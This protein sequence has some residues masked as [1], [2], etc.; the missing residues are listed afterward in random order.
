MA[1][2]DKAADD[3]ATNDTG[4]G[5]SKTNDLSRGLGDQVSASTQTR[6]D[7]PGFLAKPVADKGPIELAQQDDG[8]FV[9][10]PSRFVHPS[11]KTDS[12]T[13]SSVNDPVKVMQRTD[14]TPPW[15]SKGGSVSEV[16]LA[17]DHFIHGG[18]SDIYNPEQGN[19]LTDMVV[20]KAENEVLERAPLSPNDPAVHGDGPEPNFGDA[21]DAGHPGL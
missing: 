12:K 21:A 14:T 13:Y 18:A 19:G 15:F 2:K 4:E 17:P 9:G 10:Q 1:K 11:N 7:R 8:K 16:D 5:E 3:A 6:E 20:Q